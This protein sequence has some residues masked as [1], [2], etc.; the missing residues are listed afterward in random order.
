MHLQLGDIFELTSRVKAAIPST[1]EAAL[2]THRASTSN[3]VP[4]K[5]KG[6]GKGK[7][8]GKGCSG[9]SGPPVNKRRRAVPTPPPSDTDSSDIEDEEARLHEVATQGILVK[10]KRGYTTYPAYLFDIPPRRLRTDNLKEKA[11]DC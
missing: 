11:H 4:P 9:S 5:G 7:G 6:K 1:S 2:P 8:V 10:N 3:N